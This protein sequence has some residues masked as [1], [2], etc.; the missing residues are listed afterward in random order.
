VI[1]QVDWIDDADMWIKKKKKKKI[2]PPCLTQKR[3]SIE[4]P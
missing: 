2:R 1:Y 4:E 3:E